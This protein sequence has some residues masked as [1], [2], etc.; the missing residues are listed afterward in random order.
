MRKYRFIA[1]GTLILNLLAAAVVSNQAQAAD[2]A[3]LITYQH[4]GINRLCRESDGRHSLKS[5]LLKQR[6]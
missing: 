5:P 1:T 2:S 6:L 4:D 3:R